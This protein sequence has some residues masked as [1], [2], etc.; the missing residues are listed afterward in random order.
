VRVGVA[1]VVA[2]VVGAVAPAEAGPGGPVVE[3]RG[4]YV[5]IDETSGS[6]IA[7]HPGSHILFVNRCAGGCTLTPG[8]DDSR[9]N[10]SSIIGTTR[11]ISEYPYGDAQWAQVM[12][13]V[14]GIYAPFD[15]MVTDEDPGPDVPHFE[16]IAA[17]RAS[18]GGQFP[19]V[20]GVSPF[21][22]G[23]IENAITFSFAIDI[24]AS[25]QLLCEVVGQESAHAFGLDHEYLC[26]DLMTY[27][28]GCGPKRFVDQ[29]A[30]CGEGNPRTCMCGGN[31][32]NSYQRILDL[33]GPSVPPTPP[34]VAIESPGQGDVVRPGFT[35]RVAAS[36]NV[37]VERVEVRVGGGSVGAKTAPPYEFRAPVD[38]AFGQPVE[39]EAVA[40][41]DRGATS[42]DT[43][44]VFVG[45]ACEDPGDCQAGETCVDGRCVPFEIPGGLG[46]GCTGDADCLSGIC[47]E[48]LGVCT[49]AC[50]PAADG[51][52]FGFECQT[53]SGGGGA[54]FR[55]GGG[56]VCS[57][58]A[59]SG[60]PWVALALLG[61]A[62]LCWRR[63]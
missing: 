52:P 28:S 2:I 57:V 24:G 51:C 13:C 30:P 19:G 12:D 25:P 22:C 62:F 40:R 60:I 4:R 36:D 5:A 23:V 38:L 37:G 21:T 7:D 53:V 47:V 9:A 31:T 58:G 42:T 49:E 54:C 32:Q 20:L 8:G 33:F 29:D 61:F 15:V 17:G 27:L 18:E 45:E 63:R 39:V 14:R 16:A 41:D 35:I 26:E 59:R 46:D 44:T 43:I 50:D 55:G 10:R 3:P 56:C 48:E 6:V 11:T 34:D 1:A